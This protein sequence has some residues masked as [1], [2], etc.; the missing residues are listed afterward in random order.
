MSCAINAEQLHVHL[1]IQENFKANDEKSVIM[2]KVICQGILFFLLINGCGVYHP[3]TIDIPL[4][5][6]KND[7]R[8]DAGISVVP[9]VHSTISYGLTKKLAIQAFG[10]VGSD[11]YYFQV[12][13]GLYKDLG[14]QRVMEFYGGFGYGYGDIYKDANPGS[15][16]GN[17]QLY[18]VQYNLGKYATG[19]QHLDYGFGIK[20]GYFHSILTDENYYKFYSYTGP[21][22]I[23][24]ENSLLIEPV[25]FCR[26]GGERVKFR[27]N[28]GLSWIMKIS[29]PENYIP[30]AIFNMGFG[31]NFTPKTR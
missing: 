5:R 25:I 7:L 11:E 30:V 12:A 10:S 9:T 6:E 28:A 17:Y 13:P 20:T 3:Q 29:N 4:I 21:Y 24:D 8:I 18:F 16:F 22:D 26:L 19:S 15:M 14:R 2:R 1:D 31:I 27:I 23:Y